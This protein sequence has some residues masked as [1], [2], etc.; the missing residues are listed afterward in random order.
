MIDLQLEPQVQT[1][2]VKTCG[3]CRHFRPH[4]DQVTKRAHPSKAGLCGWEHGA[5][6]PLPM[7][8]YGGKTVWD[9]V[10]KCGMTATFK[11]QDAQDCKCWEGK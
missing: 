8:S 2:L 10:R 7:A 6:I 11:W 1:P 9:A 5:N 3:N 4:V